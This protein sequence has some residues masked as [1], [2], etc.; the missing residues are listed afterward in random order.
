LQSQWIANQARAKKLSLVKDKHEKA[1]A[2]AANRRVEH[3][4]LAEGMAMF[5]QYL[6]IKCCESCKA[7]P[8]SA[9]RLE[10]KD[11]SSKGD[12]RL[13]G[14]VQ[15]WPQQPG[16]FVSGFKRSAGDMDPAGCT[17]GA[18]RAGSS[19]RVPCRGARRGAGFAPT[20]TTKAAG[21]DF[22]ATGRRS[23]GRRAASATRAKT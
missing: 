10:P 9:R 17:P 2:E 16:R 4:D 1:L 15:N 5:K 13:K 20:A 22:F 6:E 21:R 8:K 11:W 12:I 23:G 14:H 3:P 18:Q 7:L 19:I